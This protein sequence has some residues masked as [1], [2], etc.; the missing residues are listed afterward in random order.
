MNATQKQNR[1]AKATGGYIT[2][3]PITKNRIAEAYYRKAMTQEIERTKTHR[4]DFAQPGTGNKD[5]DQTI[6]KKAEPQ[7]TR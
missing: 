7:R 4:K 6:R 3:P 5:N 2:L 1:K